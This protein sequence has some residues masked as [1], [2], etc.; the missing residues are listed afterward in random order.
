MKKYIKL[1]LSIII[2]VIILITA[3]YNLFTWKITLEDF[4]KITNNQVEIFNNEL[5]QSFQ[6][7]SWI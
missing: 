5:D 7:W 2:T 1:W 6:T 3:I 4:S